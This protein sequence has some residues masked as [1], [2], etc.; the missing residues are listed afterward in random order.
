MNTLQ[1]IASQSVTVAKGLIDDDEEALY[2]RIGRLEKA[3]E[4]D[5]ILAYSPLLDPPYEKEQMGPLD[6]VRELGRRIV[7]KW[8]AALH[9]LVCG[10][11]DDTAREQLL[12]A[13][14]VSEAAAIGVVT[15]LLLPVLSPAIAAAVAVVIVKKFL[16]PAGGVF[17]DYWGEQLNAAP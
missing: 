1:D 13:L 10:S 12:D 14:N 6:G 9:D 4:K 5:P 3:I 17:C 7:R 16:V 8:A 11:K 15:T 2:V